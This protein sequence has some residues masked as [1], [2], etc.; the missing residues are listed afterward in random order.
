M[1]FRPARRAVSPDPQAVRGLLP[2]RFLSAAVLLTALT[3]SLVGIPARLEELQRVSIWFDRIRLSANALARATLAVEV[4]MALVFF[5]CAT[6]LLLRK[7]DSPMALFLAMTLAAIGAVETGMSDALISPLQ[8]ASIPALRA[9]V[10][11]LRA[12]EM[13]GALVLL[14]IFPDGRFT[15]RWTRWLAFAWIV[16][17]AVCAWSPA[18]RSTR[19]MG[20][21]G[22]PRRSRRSSSA[23]P[24]SATGIFAQGYRLRHSRRYR[25][26]PTAQVDG[27][28]TG[29]GRRRH[30]GLL[31]CVVLGPEPRL[32]LPF[33]QDIGETFYVLLRPVLLGV[34]LAVF[35]ICLSIAVLQYHLFDIDLVI[36]R[37]LVWGTLTLLT[38]GLYV[39]IV[40]ALSVFF[41]TSNSPLAFFL[42]TG[43]I[44]VLFQPVRQRLQRAVNRLMYGERDDPYAVLSRLGQRLGGT[45]A[46]DAVAPAIVESIGAALKLPYVALTVV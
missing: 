26:A 9:P 32:A 11:T 1:P 15:P 14:Y 4:G 6:V 3:V 7:P 33:A 28:R 40:G 36:N 30:D 34:S 8:V 43:V 2:L 46:P 5:A 29:A 20:P 45:L 23:W 22:A 12:L 27:G 44:A 41:R 13:A 37:A 35:P 17:I 24:G 39:L 21:P 19:W 10:W 25:R 18:P 31:R 38:M 16:Y 42:A